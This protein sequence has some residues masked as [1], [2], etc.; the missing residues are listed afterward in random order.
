MTEQELNFLSGEMLRARTY[1]EFGSGNS[2]IMAASLPHLRKI[3]V[4][5]SDDTFFQANVGADENVRRAIESERLDYH[6]I[7]VGETGAWGYPITTERM[8]LWPSY[9]S[10]VFHRKS[11]YDLILVDGRF[12]VACILQAC[13]KCGN[14]SYILVHDFFNRPTYFVVLPFLNLLNRVDTF[15]LFKP[16][17]RQVKRYRSLIKLYIDIYQYHPEV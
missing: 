9:S 4:V 14:R 17:I 16:D 1:L 12:R 6:Y 5:E 3:T 8:D 10:S 15:A 13:L 7:N 2:T 11:D